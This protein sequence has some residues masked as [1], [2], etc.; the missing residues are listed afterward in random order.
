MCKVQNQLLSNNND[1]K[2]KLLVFIHGPLNRVKVYLTRYNCFEILMSKYQYNLSNKHQSMFDADMRV[3]KASKT[4]AVLKDFLTDLHDLTLLDIGSSSGIMT[5]EYSIFFNRVIG[6]DIDSK[7]VNFARK[8]FQTKNIEYFVSPI[9]E[10]EFKPETVDVITCSHIYEHVPSA[11]VLFNKIY[12]L[13]KPGGVCYF[14]AQNRYNLN[15]IEAHHKLPFL[16]WVPKKFANYYIRLFTD[17][18]EYYETHLSY[19][20]LKKLVNKFQINDYTLEIL[21]YPI[22]YSAEEMFTDGS[23]IQRLYIYI[24]KTF[25][26]FFPTYIWVLKKPNN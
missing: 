19:R 26:V 8:N 17:E 21:K 12:E 14:A 6:I 7:A 3:K 20:N 10:S 15:I 9:E 23:F 5:K 18:K 16:S 11:E 22:K 13:L 24:G 25:Y 1:K 4:L 2:I